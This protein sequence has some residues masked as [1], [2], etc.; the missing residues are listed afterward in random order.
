VTGQRNGRIITFY[1]YKGGVGRTMA[2]AN[3]AWILASNGHR[4]LASD[5]DLETPGG[6]PRYYKPFLPQDA[7]GSTGLIDLFSDFANALRNS[8][9]PDAEL[10]QRHAGVEH[11]M[12]VEWAFPEA[13][14][15]NYLSAGRQDRDY[16]ATLA[17]FRWEDL[18]TRFL[19]ALREQ[20]R[21]EYDYILIDSRSGLGSA[22]DI[23]VR[24]LPDVLVSCFTL[25]D[26][27]IDGAARTALHVARNAPSRGIRIL[28][29][30]MRVNEQQTGAFTAGLALARA[31]FAD[32]PVP[33]HHW[34]E[35]RIPHSTGYEHEEI[36]ATFKDAPGDPETLL[37]AYEQLAST[38]TGGH[39]T[40]LPALDESLRKYHLGAYVRPLSPQ[41]TPVALSSVPRD[42]MWADWVRWVLTRAGFQVIPSAFGAGGQG[43]GTTRTV[44]LVSSA[45]LASP[46]SRQDWP[47][48]AT[49]PAPVLL[50]IDEG[51]VLAAPF[52]QY[53]PIELTTL[54]AGRA[55]ADVLRAVG[56]HGQTRPTVPAP[57]FPND[58]PT[59]W[60]APPRNPRFV[61]RDLQ[62]DN[63][64]DALGVSRRVSVHAAT[65]G[66][67]RRQLAVEYVHRFRADYDLVWWVPAMTRHHVTRS[68]AQLTHRLDLPAVAQDTE[69]AARQ[70]LSALEGGAG[71]AYSR[72]LLVYDD[73]TEPDKLSGLLPS[74]T[75]RVLVT[76]R[77][78]AWGERAHSL[79]LG[80]FS[81]LGLKK[82]SP[83]ERAEL[84][85]RRMP[86]LSG[87]EADDLATILGDMPPL[88]LDQVGA[89]LAET[90]SPVDDCLAALG[91][92]DEITETATRRQ[93]MA[94]A[95]T[96]M[97]EMA[98][99]KRSPAA[100]RLLQV[101]CFAPLPLPLSAIRSDATL[102][103]LRPYDASLGN[104]T[105]LDSLIAELARFCL[106]EADIPGNALRVHR[107]VQPTVLAELP[108]D[109][110]E[111][112]HRDLY[113]ILDAA[114]PR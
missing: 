41:V 109:E 26:Q 73:A 67:G 66:M 17:S 28:P 48:D 5:W 100:H 15:L 44:M 58:A 21:A 62:L 79:R 63:V 83:K 34:E 69:T 31:R 84:L 114:P 111:S 23:C 113:G 29:L 40:R 19:D 10:Y 95:P 9:R 8:G 43:P 49:G 22:V 20:W 86:S 14:R 42:R 4:V 89:W 6:L 85:R 53:K 110:R 82:F 32:V 39:V 80:K 99:R 72:W 65:M 30:P 16:H 35:N 11:A 94:E 7:L 74:G 51:A 37:T 45:Y 75:G 52:D 104:L 13:G 56:G 60:Q 78:P 68:L 1:S 61:G 24:E 33:L 101:C 87:F 112:A 55:R 57:S 25:N 2:L 93:G 27:S 38:I 97:A 12:S 50:R 105:Q 54:D 106:A 92:M 107:L 103:A 96:R 77:D 46:R 70:A 36:L 59:L 3:V 18:D 64:H 98:L 71:P 91:L 81:S 102:A 90:D 88:A 47:T 108:P 76:V